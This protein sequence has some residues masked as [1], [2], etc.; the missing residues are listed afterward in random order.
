MAQTLFNPNMKDSRTMSTATD[1]T[2]PAIDGGE[3]TR[4]IPMPPRHLFGEEEKNAAIAVFDQCIETGEVFGYHGEHEKRYCEAFCKFQGGGYADAVSSGTAAIYVALRALQ[5]PLLSEVIVPPVGDPGTY[6][7]VPLCGL[8]PVVADASPNSYNT[9]A[10]QIEARLTERTSAIMV[11]HVAG[12]PVEM[13]PIME[14]AKRHGIPVIEDCAQSHGAL[15]RGQKV[16]TFGDIA[17]FSTMSGKHHATSG[18]G[19]VVYTQNESLYWQARRA[20][21]RGKPFNLPAGSTNSL[22]SL[23]FNIDE[24]SCA[25][26]CAQLEKLPQIIAKRRKVMHALADA[27]ADLKTLK[28]NINPVAEAEPSF[29]FTFI[30]LDLSKLSCDYVHFVEGLKAEGIPALGSY[31]NTPEAWDW[32]R[33]RHA[34]SEDGWPWTDPR[35]TGD[36][37]AEYPVPNL[38]K[39]DACHLRLRMHEGWGER[40]IEDT[41]TALRKLETAYRKA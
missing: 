9:S 39:T 33:H 28:I 2:R 26:G 3:K 14:L 37:N 24:L 23:N 40:E 25:I 18:Q 7:P 16:G 11:V 5:L 19:G 30:Q 13:G 35:Y 1:K 34:I 38:R 32:Y 22:A 31:F 10:E 4:S 29:W 17:A 41:A 21:D 12:I 27:T 36:P 15:Y 8:I 20:A 6:M